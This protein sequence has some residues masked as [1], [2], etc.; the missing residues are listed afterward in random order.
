MAGVTNICLGGTLGDEDDKFRWIGAR[1]EVDDSAL[2]HRLIEIQ[3]G[4][5]CDDYTLSVIPPELW[6][7]IADRKEHKNGRYVVWA[8]AHWDSPC[9]PSDF[10]DSIR[11][12]VVGY[13]LILEDMV[14]QG[15]FDE[16]SDVEDKRKRKKRKSGSRT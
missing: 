16:D 2:Q 5:N 11:D 8:D 14:A 4:S 6:N 10:S 12:W 9:S 1:E 15:E 3:P 7:Q 13:V